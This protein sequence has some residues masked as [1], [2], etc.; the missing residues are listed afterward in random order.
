M[1]D[2]EKEKEE[3]IVHTQEE[4]KPIE[5]GYMRIFGFGSLVYR[6]SAEVTCPNLRN[7][8]PAFVKDAIRV[9]GKVNLR[10][11]WRGDVDW[12]S[13]KVAS[14]FLEKH[15]GSV[16]HGVSF[17]IPLREWPQI[18]A[19]EID[20]DARTIE[21]FD[22]NGKSIGRAITFFGYKSDEDFLKMMS[23]GD[24]VYLQIRRNGYDGEM[25]RDNIYPGDDYLGKCLN[26]Y[27]IAGEAAYSNFLDT[28]FLSDR[29]TT[30]R[31]YMSSE[32]VAPYLK[33]SKLKRF[34]DI[35]KSR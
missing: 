35:F 11:A 10:A 17:D 16:V 4:H 3:E 7:F 13:M 6:Q 33:Q 2:K 9:F 1:I 12:D 22:M 27:K 20:Y 24:K 21:A 34:L 32:I 26:A 15:E 18:R 30:L 29:K 8:R 19:R 14:C 28:T 31:E 25:Y 23:E 5:H